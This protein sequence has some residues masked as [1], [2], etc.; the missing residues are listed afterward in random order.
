MR[1]AS[2]RIPASAEKTAR[3]I[4]RATRRHH[5]AEEK[6]LIVLEDSMRASA[7]TSPAISVKPSAS[8]SS[9]FAR[10]AGL[11]DLNEAQRFFGEGSPTWNVGAAAKD[12]VC[13]R[14][15]LGTIC[16]LGACGVFGDEF[17]Q[18]LLSEVPP[19]SRQ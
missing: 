16:F 14:A 1:Q 13:K 6:I 18:H 4:R 7:R 3:D 17:K 12:V 15:L 2:K 10:A 19:T 11:D 9:W 8:S 5:S